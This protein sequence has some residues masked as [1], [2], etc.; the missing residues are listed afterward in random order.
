MALNQIERDWIERR[1]DELL[2]EITEARIDIATLKIKASLWGLLGGL[3]P[4]VITLAIY[5][6]I[7][8]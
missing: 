2:K 3:I 6:L 8:G 7:K 5:I 4:V 1:F